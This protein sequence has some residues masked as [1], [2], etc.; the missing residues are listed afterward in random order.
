MHGPRKLTFIL[1]LIFGGLGVANHFVNLAKYV[2]FLSAVPDYGF[3]L[4]ALG[5]LLLVLGCIFK[6]I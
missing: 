4:L 1:A 5:W 2:P 6:K 3:W